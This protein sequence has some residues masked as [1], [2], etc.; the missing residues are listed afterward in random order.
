MPPPYCY[1]HPRPAVTVDTLVFTLDGD[2]IRMLMVRRKAEP[3]AGRWA[4]PGGFLEIDEEIED[5]VLRELR[6]ETGLDEVAL[7]APIGVFGELDRDPRGRTITLAHAAAVRGPAPEVTASDD[8][9]EA[10]WLEPDEVDQFAFDHDQIVAEGLQWLAIGI[11][12]GPVALV[13]LPEVF[14]DADVKRL[15]TAIGAS[16][17]DA[18]AWCHEMLENGVI[19]T[20]PGTPKRYQG[21]LAPEDADEDEFDDEADLTS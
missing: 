2:A 15:H 5:A 19:T 21:V 6:E 14:D 12:M 9:A 8:A 11:E 20:L 7:L 18:S 1:D 16:A 4:I 13:L 17:R 10:A 3:F